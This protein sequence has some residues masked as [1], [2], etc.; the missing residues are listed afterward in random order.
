MWFD[1]A[2]VAC[3]YLLGSIP[4]GLLSSKL[5]AGI[6]PRTTGS[7]NIGFTNVLRVSGKKAGT[8]ALIGDVGKGA[9]ATLGL[10]HAIPMHVTEPHVVLLIAFAVVSGHCYSVFLRFQGGK[11]VAT[12]L[13]SILGFDVFLGLSVLAIWSIAIAIWKY[14]A[15]GALIT[16]VALPLIVLVSDPTTDRILFSICITVI[17]WIR[18]KDNLKRLFA[19]TEPRIGSKIS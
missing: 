11:G 2:Q 18:H 7:G 4:F 10:P 19:G 14:A 15:I 1:F 8:Y 5:I 12:A 3:A 9:L 13:G 6:D 17:I 16:S